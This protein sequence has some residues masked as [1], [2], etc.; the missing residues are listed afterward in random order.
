MKDLF[1]E[2]WNWSEKETGT[3]FNLIYH[4]FQS[5]P[6]FEKEAYVSFFD[7]SILSFSILSPLTFTRPL[8]SPTRS[9]VMAWLYPNTPCWLHFIQHTNTTELLRYE[10]YW[11]L[12]CLKQLELVWHGTVSLNFLGVSESEKQR[13]SIGNYHYDYYLALY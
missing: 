5:W 12:F 2:K 13:K 4:F 3:F 6:I 8:L 1:W 7:V 11:E 10:H 9:R